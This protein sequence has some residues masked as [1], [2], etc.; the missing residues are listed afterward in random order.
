[1]V[2]GGLLCEVCGDQD[3]QADEQKK[4]PAMWLPVLNL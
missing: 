4:T 3:K 1:M 2:M